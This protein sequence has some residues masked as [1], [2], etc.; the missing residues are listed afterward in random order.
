MGTV[1]AIN[2]EDK[3]VYT[4]S[5]TGDLNNAIDVFKYTP[6][7]PDGTP[8]VTQSAHGGW[9]LDGAPLNVYIE[10]VWFDGQKELLTPDWN[11]GTVPRPSAAILAVGSAPMPADVAANYQNY[12]TSLNSIPTAVWVGGAALLAWKFLK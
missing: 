3:K 5:V 7:R 11:S 2:P 10:G 8:Y 6:I 4:F 1:N 9:L 12:L